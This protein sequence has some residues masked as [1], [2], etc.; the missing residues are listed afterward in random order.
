M[1]T[2]FV[3]SPPSSAATT[4][5]ATITPARSWASSVDAARCGVTT[6]FGELEQRPGVRLGA[7]DVERGA[8]DLPARGAPRRSASSSTSSPRA[9]LT[10]RTP[11]RHARERLRADRAARLGGQR[12]VQGQE[13][14]G[15][16][17]PP[18]ASR[19]RSTP[20]SRKRS[21]RRTG[22]RRRRACRARP[23]GARPAGRCGRSRARRASCRPAR[24][25]PTAT[26]PSGP[27]SAPRAPAGCCARAR[28]AGR[29]C[30][31]RPR[32]RSTRA[33]SRRRS[34]AASPRSTSTLSTPTP[35]RPITFSR[36]PSAISSAV[37]FVAERMTIAV[38]AADRLGEVGVAV[39]VDV[40]ALAEQAGRRRRRST[41][42][43]GRAGRSVT[44][45]RAARTRR[46]RPRPPTPRSNVDAGLDEPELDCRRARS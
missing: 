1:L 6:T 33:R 36:S 3:T 5:S 23:R 2:A 45:G 46:A 4:C 35:A 41:R 19:A 44:R 12:Q 34:R 10:I 32:R 7:E 14:R 17:R 39:D 25:R 38:V 43:R 37:S 11:R 26:A 20:S 22:R 18:P 30:A 28:R 8:G 24:P 21:A 13:V 42:G 29:S 40:E 9:A 15:R 27:P 31:P 16:D